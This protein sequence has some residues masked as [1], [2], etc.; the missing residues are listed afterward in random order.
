MAPGLN[1]PMEDFSKNARRDML[2]QSMVKIG[3]KS[4]HMYEEGAC[5]FEGKIRLSIFASVDIVRMIFNL[6]D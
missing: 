5:G 2:T 3:F 4:I 6:Y 1:D